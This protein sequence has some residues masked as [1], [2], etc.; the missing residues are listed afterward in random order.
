MLDI[1]QR[2]SFMNKGLSIFQKLHVR[3]DALTLM[4]FG[5]NSSGRIVY[6]IDGIIIFSNPCLCDMLFLALSF[7]FLP[8][9]QLK[10]LVAVVFKTVHYM[11]RIGKYA[12]M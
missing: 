5:I 4:W 8:S 1:Y 9:F 6:R 11:L 7:W 12:K 3:C 10:D 2:I